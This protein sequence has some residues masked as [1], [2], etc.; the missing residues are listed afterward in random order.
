[1]TSA[2]AGALRMGLMC[3]CLR[4]QLKHAQLELTQMADD[5][6]VLRLWNYDSE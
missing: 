5:R 2:A 1:M 6:R 3:G 4:A